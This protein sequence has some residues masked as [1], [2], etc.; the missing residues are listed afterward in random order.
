MRDDIGR[1][2]QCTQQK[3]P[4]GNHPVPVVTREKLGSFIFLEVQ[5]GGGG[6]SHRYLMEPMQHLY[7]GKKER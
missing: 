5:E 4:G 2:F 6:L 7:Q 1:M 3:K